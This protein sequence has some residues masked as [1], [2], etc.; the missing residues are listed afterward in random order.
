VLWC[1]LTL[2]E[3]KNLA[4][5]SLILRLHTIIQC[6]SAHRGPEHAVLRVQKIAAAEPREQLAEIHLHSER[7]ITVRRTAPSQSD[8]HEIGR[9]C[10]GTRPRRHAMSPGRNRW[11]R[12]PVLPLCPDDQ[13]YWCG[14]PCCSGRKE[15]GAHPALSQH[16]VANV[17]VVFPPLTRQP[18]VRMCTASARCP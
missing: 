2:L 18:P 10:A 3:L 4:P 17:L 14:G 6:R 7:T 15:S 11:A 16:S 9:G 13:R 5:E 8:A 12:S 1:S